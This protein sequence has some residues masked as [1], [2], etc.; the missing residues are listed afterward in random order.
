LH[1]KIIGAPKKLKNDPVPYLG[2][3]FTIHVIKTQNDLMRQSLKE[4]LYN[5]PAQPSQP[6]QQRV[7]DPA[8]RE[9]R[10][11]PH[12]W[13]KGATG[14]DQI[15]TDRAVFTEGQ[16]SQ[17]VSDLTP[18]LMRDTLLTAGRQVPQVLIKYIQLGHFSQ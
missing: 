17:L 6:G 12:S 15:H 3:E 7:F 4:F 16:C 5:L 1:Y 13:Q 18:Q 2:L 14:P 9:G 8:V 10:Y 11:A